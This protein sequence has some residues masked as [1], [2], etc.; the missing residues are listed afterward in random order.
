MEYD[1]EKYKS[2]GLAP[3]FEKIKP[4]MNPG[5]VFIANIEHSDNPAHDAFYSISRRIGSLLEEGNYEQAR[6]L[7]VAFDSDGFPLTRYRALV[8]TLKVSEA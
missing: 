3:M 7:E 1:R 4:L 8:G 5:E 2:K 6:V